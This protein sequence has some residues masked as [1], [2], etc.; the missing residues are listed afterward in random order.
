LLFK[1]L[2][3]FMRFSVYQES[4]IGGRRSIRIAWD[5][6]LPVM[7]LLLLADMG[8][9]ILG[10]MAAAIAMQTIGS[11]FQ[12]QAHPLVGR[13][14]R[15]LEDSFLAAHQEIHRYHTLNNL[16]ETPRTTIVA[17]LIQ[18]G[19]AYWAHC[20]DSR[21]YWMRQG[22]IL[23]RTK[24]HS[25]LETLI[26]Q[27]GGSIGASHILIAINCSTVWVR[28]MPLL[29]SFAACC[30]AAGRYYSALLRRFLVYVARSYAGST[31]ARTHHCSCN[32]GTD[33]LSGQYCWQTQR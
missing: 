24:D 23:L 6:A 25:R 19:Y 11:L 33:T 28:R 4:H 3:L 26:A 7:I 29:L 15:F 14:E 17:C 9:H 5:I 13:P 20:G 8:G 32:S 2:L 12:Q 10:E 27:E 31:F 30:I 16:P 1:A 18:N 22:Q 21:L